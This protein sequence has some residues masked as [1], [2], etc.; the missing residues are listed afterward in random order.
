MPTSQVE[1]P[2]DGRATTATPYSQMEVENIAID[3]VVGLARSPRGNNAIWVIVDRLTKSAH[4]IPFR[5]G[6]S[7]EHW[8]RSTYRK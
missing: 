4:F 3:F 6:Q 8:Q 1:T 5:V 7:T 2:E